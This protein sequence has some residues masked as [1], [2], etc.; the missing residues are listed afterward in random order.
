VGTNFLITHDT[1]KL[2]T[3]LVDVNNFASR[4]QTAAGRE[5]FTLLFRG[6]QDPTFNQDTY[7]IE[8]EKLGLFSFLMVPAKTRDKGA[9]YYAAVVNRLHS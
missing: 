8:H 7:I 4:Q 1:G 9:A 3:T 6:P 2:K 5:G